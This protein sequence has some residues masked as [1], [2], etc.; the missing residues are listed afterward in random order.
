[1]NG[2]HELKSKGIDL[3]SCVRITYELGSC[4]P[5]CKTVMVLPARPG[6]ANHYRNYDLIQ[7]MAPPPSIENHTL[8]D[9]WNC[10]K[11][12]YGLTAATVIT[13]AAGIPLPKLIFGAR[14]HPGASKMTNLSSFVGW[15][16]FPRTLIRQPTAAR[17]AKSTFG[18]VRVFGVIGRGIPFVAAGLAIFDLVSIG[19]CAYEARN[20]KYPE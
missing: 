10:T 18:T 19:L 20:A 12:H 2:V 9:L 16:F 5:R 1:M 4:M 11:E 17:L 6:I 15:K 14:V 8:E 3:G 13:G 7:D